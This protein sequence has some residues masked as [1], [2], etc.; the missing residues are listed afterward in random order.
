MRF[1]IFGIQVTLLYSLPYLFAITNGF[2]I[3]NI[4]RLISI[5]NMTSPEQAMVLVFDKESNQFK[6]DLGWDRFE[7]VLRYGRI[8]FACT[9]QWVQLILGTLVSVGHIKATSERTFPTK[10]GQLSVYLADGYSYYSRL[11]LFKFKRV[12]GYTYYIV[13][14]DGTIADRREHV[15][16]TSRVKCPTVEDAAALIVELLDITETLG[17]DIRAIMVQSASVTAETKAI[18]NKLE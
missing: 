2:W 13:R 14:L 17:D 18:I 7:F 3:I 1:R 15:A 4:P 6:L 8:K 16:I 11:S 12:S 9:V 10:H 5:T